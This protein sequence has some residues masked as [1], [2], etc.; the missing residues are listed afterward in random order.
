MCTIK[1]LRRWKM[2]HF[3]KIVVFIE[4]VRKS[5]K[6]KDNIHLEFVIL[7]FTICINLSYEISD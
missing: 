4:E 5:I 7:L 2:Q 3:I 6:E 1:N